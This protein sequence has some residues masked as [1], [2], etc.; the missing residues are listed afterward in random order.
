MK[1]IYFGSDK[2]EF[3]RGLTSVLTG[4]LAEAFPKITLN[5]SKELLINPR[6]RRTVKFRNIIPTEELDIKTI[7]GSVHLYHFVGGEKHFLVVHGWADSTQSMETIIQT[8]LSQGHTV[9]A[10]DHIGHGLSEGNRSHLFGYIEG[11]KEVIRE[12]EKKGLHLSGVVAHSMGGAAIINLG[13]DFLEDKKLVMMGVPVRIFESMFDRMSEVGISKKV[14]DNLL[15]SISEEFNESW[16]NLHPLKHTDKIK[17][18][19]MFIHDKNDEQC[20]YEDV[21]QLLEGKSALSYLTE[22]L[23][24]RKIL[25]DQNVMKKIVE[26]FGE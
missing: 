21:I 16:K 15:D 17:N 24:H 20:S 7:L 1:S 13:A 18:N 25:R 10:M 26:F 6:G 4:L 3:V 22:N 5:A 14:L 23:G 9:W 19:F 12:I 11:L 2:S 8:L